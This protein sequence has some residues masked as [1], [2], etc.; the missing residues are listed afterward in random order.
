M[1]LILIRHGE[2]ARNAG[3][4]ALGRDDVPLND[5]GRLQAQC[6]T[7]RLAGEPI[8]AVYASPLQRAV[9]TATPLA[10]ALRLTIEVQPPLIEMD[11]GE[12]EGMDFA[13]LRQHY[14]DFLQR[15]LSDDV[16]DAVMPG[17]ESLAQVQERAWAT[18]DALREARDD[19][20][21][22][23]VS[24]NFV[25]LTLL[26]RALDLPLARFRRLRQ[27]LGGISWVELDA[28]RARVVT[29]NE[30]SHL[31]GEGL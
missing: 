10:E 9:D 15:W 20:T 22:A 1:R 18:I 4:I 7:S 26:C 29:M 17:G 27:D 19:D 8:A 16:A 28:E 11:I 3:G 2:T 12:L 14:P 24:H 5:R 25:I 21:V 6:V 31:Q 13:T 23:V 30:T